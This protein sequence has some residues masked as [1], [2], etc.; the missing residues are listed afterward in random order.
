M[1]SPQADAAEPLP[2]QQARKEYKPLTTEDLVDRPIDMEQ[3]K[4][5]HGYHWYETMIVLRA[6]LDDLGR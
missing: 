1:L 5:P 3:F 2:P 4:L 6:M